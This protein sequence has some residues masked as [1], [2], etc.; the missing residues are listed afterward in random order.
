MQRLT[1]ALINRKQIRR[2]VY[3]K[4]LFANG[5]DAYFIIPEVIV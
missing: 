1:W 3:S 2:F 5:F 4:I